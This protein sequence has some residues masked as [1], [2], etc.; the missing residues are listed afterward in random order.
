MITNPLKP[1]PLRLSKNHHPIV[2]RCVLKD[3][4]DYNNPDIHAIRDYSN[5]LNILFMTRRYEPHRYS[6]DRDII[7][8]LP[9]FHIYKNS[10]YKDTFYTDTEPINIINDILIDYYD[11]IERRKK[12]K[13]YFRYLLGRFSESIV[14]LFRR[15]TRMETVGTSSGAGAGATA[16][17]SVTVAVNW[18]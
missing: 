11:G 1:E 15:K 9:A 2:V 7:E 4:A 3:L 13:N 16:T 5:S 17:A 12:R 14:K 10:G 8:R 6:E 18:K